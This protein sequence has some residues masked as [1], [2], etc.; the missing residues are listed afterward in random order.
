MCQHK[1]LSELGEE[2]WYLNALRLFVVRVIYKHRKRQI[3]SFQKS[4]N[5]NNSDFLKKIE[6]NKF[7]PGEIVRVKSKNEIYK[8]LD[9]DGKYQRCTFMEG[10]YDCCGKTY[11]IMQ[12]IDYFYEG[13]LKKMCRGKNLYVLEGITCDGKKGF[14]PLEVCNLNCYY[15][16]HG[17]WL[18]KIAET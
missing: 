9:A 18:E 4:V 2:R 11:T 3:A 8:I 13:G 14:L 10:M 16:W 5:S 17:A 1:Y 6:V 12:E 15:F 7:I